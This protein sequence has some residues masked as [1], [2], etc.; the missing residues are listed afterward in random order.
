MTMYGKEWHS[1]AW[2]DTWLSLTHNPLDLSDIAEMS[3]A[4]EG[5]G[6]CL[7]I[8]A[9]LTEMH[10]PR[11]SSSIQ[12]NF[13]TLDSSRESAQFHHT[14]LHLISRH[15]RWRTTEHL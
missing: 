13:S 15:S 6:V 14:Y 8:A 11:C 9:M 4:H 12:L 5:G 10:L 2:H 1:T 3:L 7:P